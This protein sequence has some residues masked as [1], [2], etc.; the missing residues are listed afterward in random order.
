MD[1]ECVVSNREFTENVSES[2]LR[3]IE[4]NVGQAGNSLLNDFTLDRE[5]GR[6]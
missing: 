6:T 3:V 5:K 2:E 4:Y 1:E